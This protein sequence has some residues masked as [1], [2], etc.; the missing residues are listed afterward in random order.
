MSTAKIAMT[1]PR[2][3]AATEV[4]KRT[5]TLL[6][7]KC[8]T[9]RPHADRQL[10][11]LGSGELVSLMMRGKKVNVNAPLVLMADGLLLQLLKTNPNLEGYDVV[12]VDE[13]HE[14]SPNLCILLGHLHRVRLRVMQHGN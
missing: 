12:I 2:R 8:Y 11:P 13:V 3:I 1:Q 14:Q 7:S 6:D 5:G 4:A 9:E 10:G